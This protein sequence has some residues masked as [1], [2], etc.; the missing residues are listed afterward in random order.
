MQQHTY[1]V[2]KQLKAGTSQATNHKTCESTAIEL[3]KLSRLP[4]VD[5]AAPL[6]V[7]AANRI[8]QATTANSA[9]GST[10]TTTFLTLLTQAIVKVN[11]LT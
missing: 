3:D 6:A 1:S 9:A 5:L 2:C 4:N 11:K 8:N 7:E 10:L